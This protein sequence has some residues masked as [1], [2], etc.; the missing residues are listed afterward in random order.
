MS[1]IKAIK[2]RLPAARFGRSS[3]PANGT[4]D[5]RA[6]PA[7]L[8][9]AGLS[10]RAGGL[11]MTFVPPE[12]DF[13]RASQAWQRFTS[14]DL[15]V[16]TLS[17]NGAL[18]SSGRQST[19]CD[20]AGQ[21]GSWLWLPDS[22]IAR[23]ET[24][25]I[26][27]HVQDTH[28]ASQRIT[29]IQQE[30]ER[31][32]LRMPLSADRTFAMI[33]CDGLSA[34]EGFLMQ[35]WYNSGR[36][37]CL[38][39]GGSA[40]GK[41]S[42]DGTWIGV[43]GK[44]LQG[45]AVIIF[46][47][48]AAGKS[49]A[50][51]KSQNFTPLDNSWLIA[52]ADPIARTVSSVFNRQGQQQLLVSALCTH[53]NCKQTQLTERLQGLTF[54]VRVGDEYFIRSVA[55]I[56]SDSVQFFCDLEFGDR[57]FLM[58]EKDFKQATQL[59]WQAFARQHGKPAAIL[60]N[61]CI[62]RR[63]GNAGQLHNAHFFKGIPA[64]GFSS[65]G[66]ILGVP[67]NQT[68]SAL[69]FFNH[70]VKAMSQFPVEYAGY[71]AHYAQRALRRWEAL[72]SVQTGVLDRVISYQQALTPLMEALPVLERATQSQGET[73]SLAENSIRAISDIATQSQQAQGRLDDGL[74]DLEKISHGINEITHGISNIAFQTNILALNAAVE[75]ARAGEAGRGFAVVAGEVRR[76]AHSSKE[77]AEATASNISEAVSTI[78]RIRLVASDSAQTA[79]QMAA[80]SISAADT[81]ATM[82]QQTRHERADIAKHLGSLRE[83]TQGMDAMQDAVAQLKVLQ[84]LS[85][86]QVKG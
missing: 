20:G 8:S 82:N 16:L 29:A 3:Q 47:Q 70:E 60:M 85:G 38:A 42:F 37:P 10:Q 40:G 68:L 12:A 74:D 39:I 61:D 51:F 46:C 25:I 79:T 83:L 32:Q 23:H 80:R 44:I 19:Y 67:I 84:V 45:K 66:E 4:F 41:I 14:A 58:Q 35:A 31:L 6:L 33:Y 48:M 53:L 15:T 30:L 2:K 57:L 11:L 5:C 56:E 28:T 1:I 34:S 59:E 81:L 77:Q 49:F 78:A 36:F 75:A 22:L 65:F 63:V 24:H 50:P 62:L 27:L 54:G 55:K 26:D 18:S 9:A 43:G 73:L 69:V 76:L 72:N 21:E 52:E 13:Q 86:G 71:A 64:A 7:S 17:S